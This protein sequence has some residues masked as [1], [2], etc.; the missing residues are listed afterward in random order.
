LSYVFYDNSPLNGVNSYRLKQID[1]DGNTDYSIILA[2]TFGGSSNITVSPNPADDIVVVK[3]VS[4]GQVVRLVNWQGRIVQEKTAI[5]TSVT[6]A[7]S[8]LPAALYMVQVIGKDK[9]IGSIKLSKF[10]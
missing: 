6:F 10:R 9:I 3:G 8:Q 4:T 2:I 5:G 7:I 1:L